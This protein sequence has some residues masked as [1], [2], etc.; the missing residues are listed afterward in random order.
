MKIKILKLKTND[1]IYLSYYF[2]TKKE[3]NSLYRYIFGKRDI[4]V[5]QKELQG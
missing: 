1:K 5:F 2:N 4:L 3:H